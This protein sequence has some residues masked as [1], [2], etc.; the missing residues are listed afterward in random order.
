MRILAANKFYH[1]F[2]GSD[3][4]FFELNELQRQEGHEIIPFAMHHPKNQKSVYED[5]FVSTVN[6][7]DNP[8]LSEKIQAAGRTLYST[9]AKKKIAALM[10]HARPEIA[11]IHLIYHQISPVILP[12]IKKFGLPIVQTLHDYKPICPTYSLI[13]KGSVCE[14][15]LGGHYYQVV[16]NKCNHNSL[17]ASS[18]NMVEMYFHHWMNWYDLPDI[19][20]TP[21]NFMR[22]KMIQG[23]LPSN[24]LV[25]IPNFVDTN[26]LKFSS[27]FEQYFVYLGR[28]HE[29]KGVK[30]L[31][32]A[33]KKINPKSIKLLLIGDGPQRAE[34]EQLTHNLGLQNV[35]F[36]GHQNFEALLNLL[37]NAMFNVLPSEVYENNPMSILECMALGKP[38][39]G[40]RIGGIP[41]LIEDGKDGLL[42]QSGN[43]D[44]LAEKLEELLSD[45][46]RTQAMGRAAREKVE[47]NYNPKNHL[48]QIQAIY[49]KLLNT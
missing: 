39:I 43:A 13:S 34:L 40:A 36:C 10:K 7:W 35:V 5:Y 25:H 30:T 21:S 49:N 47:L 24:K 45:T 23:G 12:V 44:D 20:I 26:K 15:C 41:E 9:E 37:S 19:Y 2:G 28:L 6:Y 14:K 48:N 22:Q 8:S 38:T 4:Y 17:M 42:F 1:I 33:F 29:I 3:R 11:H 32:N 27:K 16:L 46:K 31:L 18:V